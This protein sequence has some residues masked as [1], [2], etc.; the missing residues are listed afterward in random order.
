MD[1]AITLTEEWQM[2]ALGQAETLNLMLSLYCGTEMSQNALVVCAEVAPS[3]PGEG[4]ARARL[5]HRR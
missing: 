2:R 3:A 4:L 1:K 5:Y